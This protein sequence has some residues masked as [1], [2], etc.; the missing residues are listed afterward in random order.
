[1]RGC[2]KK[3][4]A[5]ACD[6]VPGSQAILEG[7]GAASWTVSRPHESGGAIRVNGQ[8][9][10]FRLEPGRKRACPLAPARALSG[11]ILP[12]ARE[13]RSIRR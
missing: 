7:L 9:Q 5:S 10:D 12:W 3:D 6:G 4:L 11:D 1:M 2:A 8:R 13:C